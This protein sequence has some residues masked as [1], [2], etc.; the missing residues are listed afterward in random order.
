MLS[1]YDDLMDILKQY[2]NIEK[3]DQIAGSLNFSL[4]F[5]YI[6]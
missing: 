3:Y 5:Y 4:F 2:G 1:I 6:Q